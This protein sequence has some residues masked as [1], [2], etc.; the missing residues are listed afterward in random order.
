M[1]IPYDY[2]LWY[3]ELNGGLDRKIVGPSPPS[4]V[5]SIDW[6]SNGTKIVEG[7]SAGTT[8]RLFCMYILKEH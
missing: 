7:Y 6:N 1:T 2:G 4:A 3:T 8:L 5:L